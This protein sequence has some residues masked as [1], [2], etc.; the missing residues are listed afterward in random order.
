MACIRNSKIDRMKRLLPFAVGVVLLCLL[1]AA[2]DA[3]LSPVQRG[4][5]PALRSLQ[6]TVKTKDD[7][8]LEKAIV[9]LKNDKT[10]AVRTFITGTDGQY[11]FHALSPNTDY[12]VFAEHEGRRSDTKTLSSFD[13]R[14]QAYINLKVNT[15]KS[16]K[17]DEKH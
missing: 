9:Y 2:Q 14:A 8:P 5:E 7:E 15:S 4:R 1:A 12:D 16:G 11:R 13:S 3:A 17:P 10:L 6:G